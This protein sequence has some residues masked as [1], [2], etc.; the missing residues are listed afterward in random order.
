MP[1]ILGA[2]SV[3]G[4]FQVTNGIRLNGSDEYLSRTL[5][6][7]TSS[8]TFTVSAWIKGN[9]KRSGSSDSP[10]MSVGAS[11]DHDYTNLPNFIRTEGT[12]TIYISD[13]DNDADGDTGIYLHFN[14]GPELQDPTAW[15]HVLLA[16]DT[17]QGTAAN[18]IKLY[19][20]GEQV[21]ND[22][23]SHNSNYPAQ[24]Y[25]I[26]GLANGQTIHVGAEVQGSTHRFSGYM[27]EHHYIDGQALAPTA[28]GKFQEDTGIWV[29]IRY[30]GTFGN[31]GHR[32][33][34]KQTGT[35]ANASGQGA[36]TSG[37]ANHFTCNGLETHN[38]VQDT[39]TNN[40]CTWNPL[41]TGSGTTFSTGNLDT[42]TGDN[43][44]D[45]G[46]IGLTSGKWYFEVKYAGAAI[47]GWQSEHLAAQN[48]NGTNLNDNHGSVAYSTYH[49]AVFHNSSTDGTMSNDRDGG[50][51][52]VAFDLDNNKAYW[53][54]DGTYI[55]IASGTQNPATEANPITIRSTE[56]DVHP[57]YTE[58]F[59]FP[60]LA[61]GSSS[62]TMQTNF[63]NPTFNPSSG[64]A[65]GAGYGN[66]EFS[67]PSGYY[68]ICTQNI[69]KYS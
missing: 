28:F 60:K 67:V 29:P 68:S 6:A 7:P 66:F 11:G 44:N 48:L 13:N 43:K 64:N 62:Q 41:D 27:C 3:S 15:I 57:S 65:D 51:I 38:I 25:D 9:F 8:R 34:F 49:G 22:I 47:A 2:N 53:H 37:N 58:A 61:A 54:V 31:S 19:L 63:G 30:T 59:Y 42:D 5:E 46:T 16:I 14:N 23:A 33:E 21:P 35:S 56:T 17:T 40:F 52:G 55:D 1:A 26:P 4:E 36:D 10:I 50:T 20:N 32:L 39:C 24:N 18:R 45:V 12:P 69:A